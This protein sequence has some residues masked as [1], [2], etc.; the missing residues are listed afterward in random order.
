MRGGHTSV[1]RRPGGVPA[2]QAGHRILTCCHDTGPFLAHIVDGRWV[3]STPIEPHLPVGHNAYAVRNRLD[4]PD[5]IRYPMKRVD[6]DSRRA[7]NTRNR[8]RSQFVR[9]SW[10]EALD[11]VAR[12]LQRVRQQYGPSGV[13]ECPI[14]HQWIGSLHNGRAWSDRFFAL[15]GNCSRITGNTSFTGWHPGGA[16]TW[17]YGPV[18]TNNAADILQNTRLIIHWASDVAVKRYGGYR[19]NYWLRR[20]K[21]AGIKQIVIDPYYSDTAALYGDEWMPILPETDEALMSAVAYVWIT[22]NRHDAQFLADHAIGFERFRDHVLGVT[23]KLPK[24]PQ[25]AASVCRIDADRIRALACEWASQPT[26]VLCDYGGANR[27]HAAAQWSRM[28]I[29]MQSLLGNIGRPGRGLGG[30]KYNTRGRGQKGI[31]EILTPL[32]RPA[33]QTIRHAQFADAILNPPVRW[34]TVDSSNQITEHHYPREDSA[35]VKLVAFMSGSGSFLNQIPGTPDHVR[36][37][38][39]SEI[40]FVYCHAGWWHAAPKHSDLIL[41]IRHVGERDDIVT[42]ENYTV[43]SHTLVEPAGEARNDLDILS[44]LAERIGFGGE[45]TTHKT[46]EQW[47]R[48]IHDRL[49]L[50]IRFSFINI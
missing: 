20:F 41:P 18:A 27:R 5:R 11:L 33:G 31:P 2:A 1:E 29:T 24:T 22:E 9:I 45:F 21:Q 16:L 28:I 8:G 12:E 49:G 26:Y 37:L 19:Q 34:T 48:E 39:S 38:Q 46:S 40:E 25:W 36:A 10:D 47:L 6:F 17:G 50:Q 15:L 13:L 30:L 23:D 43:Y 35:P 14:G 3:K 7:R 42:W 44:A 32:A 4:S